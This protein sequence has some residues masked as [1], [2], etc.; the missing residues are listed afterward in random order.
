M[1][2]ANLRAFMFGIKGKLVMFTKTCEARENSF[3]GVTRSLQTVAL[4]SSFFCLLC[5]FLFVSCLALP[6]IVFSSF[7]YVRVLL[8]VVVHIFNFVVIAVVWLEVEWPFFFYSSPRWS[9]YCMS[10]L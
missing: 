4:L 5:V 6:C 9:S 7:F 2:A 1:A 8:F 3:L 10:K